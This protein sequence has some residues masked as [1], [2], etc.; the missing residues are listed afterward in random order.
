MDARLLASIGQL[1]D[2]SLQRLAGLAPGAGGHRDK[3][4]NTEE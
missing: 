1:A 4:G 3:I 2:Q